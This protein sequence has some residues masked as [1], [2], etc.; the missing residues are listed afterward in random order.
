MN[1]KF[2]EG[3][4]RNLALVITVVSV[5]NSNDEEA[6]TFNLYPLLYILSIQTEF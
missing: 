6:F 4:A 2:L 5:N 3:D 1:R